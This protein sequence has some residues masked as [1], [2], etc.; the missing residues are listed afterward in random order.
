LLLLILGLSYFLWEHMSQMQDRS[1]LL[2]FQNLFE[3][4]VHLR[5]RRL[6]NA[7]GLMSLPL[8]ALLMGFLVYPIYPTSRTA[9]YALF[10]PI[11]ERSPI[12]RSSTSL[13]L[14]STPVS[15][16]AAF[17][18]SFR[19]CSARFKFFRQLLEP[20]FLAL[21]PWFSSSFFLE[22]CCHPTPPTAGFPPFSDPLSVVPPL[23]P[24]L[25]FC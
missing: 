16:E 9:G 6:A 3:H 19:V 1:L 18:P 11:L 4:A 24:Y 20:A 14:F 8:C 15:Y 17:R 12:P 5:A 25:S 7:V 23:F 2:F 22:S 13:F 21:P 10:V